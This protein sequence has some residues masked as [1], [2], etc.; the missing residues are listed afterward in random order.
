MLLHRGLTRVHS[1]KDPRLHFGESFSFSEAWRSESQSAGGGE[2]GADFTEV[3]PDDVTLETEHKPPGTKQAHGQS[4]QCR[5]FCG[6]SVHEQHTEHLLSTW[7]HRG[8]EGKKTLW[9]HFVGW[10]SSHIVWKQD[11]F[12]FQGSRIDDWIDREGTPSRL[13]SKLFSGGRQKFLDLLNHQ[14]SW[15]AAGPLLNTSA[16]F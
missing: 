5:W 7:E 11:R 14:V 15:G 3:K 8:S 6:E 12:W 2:P 13:S 10:D 16:P 4:F 1:Q 9:R